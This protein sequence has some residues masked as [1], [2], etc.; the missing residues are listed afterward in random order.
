[1]RLV[2][3]LPLAGLA[4]AVIAARRRRARIDAGAS[5]QPHAPVILPAPSLD[6][7][8]RSGDPDA[9]RRALLAQSAL[10]DDDFDALLARLEDPA[11]VD[12]LRR[13]RAARWGGGDLQAALQAV[14]E[15]FAGGARWRRT[16]QGARSLLPPLYPD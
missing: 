12:A 11:Q 3:L 4:V 16:K 1:M 9:I 2:W 6:T 8:L 5:D 10:Q 13:M 15:A 14:R 7:A